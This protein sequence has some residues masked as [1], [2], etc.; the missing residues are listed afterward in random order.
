MENREEFK[1]KLI[2]KLEIELKNYKED[3]KTK[4]PDKII[5]SAYE[6]TA[7]QEFID[8]IQYDNELSKT[9][10]KALLS[11]ENLLGELYDDWLS[12]DG[13]MRGDIEFSL[14]KSVTNITNDYL[15]NLQKI[16]SKNSRESR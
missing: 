2:K 13:N 1:E 7:K 9:T 8:S 15:D 6:L 14:D 16:K 11:R 3:L 10:I 5:E 4:T 12:F